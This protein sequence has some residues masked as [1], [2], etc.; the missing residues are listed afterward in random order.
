MDDPEA[1]LLKAAHRRNVGVEI[2]RP[3]E[4]LTWRPRP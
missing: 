4:W 3:A 2:I 1:A